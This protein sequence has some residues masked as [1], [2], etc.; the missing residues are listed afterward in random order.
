MKKLSLA[1]A[2]LFL[3]IC[4]FASGEEQLA[5]YTYNLEQGWNLI[6]LTLNPTAES[7]QELL[8]H[9]I[10]EFNG[11]RT[12]KEFRQAEELSA[13]CAYWIF[14]ERNEALVVSGT[15]VGNLVPDASED[16]SVPHKLLLGPI[17]YKNAGDEVTLTAAKK[18]GQTFTGWSVDGISLPDTT[19]PTVTFTMPAHDVTLT[20]NYIRTDNYLVINLTNGTHRYTSTAPDLSSDTCRTTEL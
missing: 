9:R 17:P 20:P 10:Y 11:D 18:E 7:E 19:Q 1:L 8:G 12:A 5:T 2:F 13:G 4:A 3:S 16:T 15:P 6:G 14:S